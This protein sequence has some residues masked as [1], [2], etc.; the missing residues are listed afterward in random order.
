MMTVIKFRADANLRG[1]SERHTLDPNRDQP[2]QGA[3]V[4]II[5]RCWESIIKCSITY[6]ENMIVQE[7]NLCDHHVRHIKPAKKTKSIEII[8]DGGMVQPQR[9]ASLRSN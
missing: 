8:L 7:R 6:T 9:Q 3:S 1:P 5:K 4:E 2:E